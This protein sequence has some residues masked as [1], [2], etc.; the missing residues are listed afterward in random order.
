MIYA[1]LAGSIGAVLI[2]WGIIWRAW[3]RNASAPIRLLLPGLALVLI[4]AAWGS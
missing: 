4:C 2:F 3:D 1:N